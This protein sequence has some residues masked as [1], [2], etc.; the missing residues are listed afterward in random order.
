MRIILPLLVA[1]LFNVIVYGAL[2]VVH[3]GACF[4]VPR[5]SS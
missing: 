2:L 4:N 5:G 3:P 1:V